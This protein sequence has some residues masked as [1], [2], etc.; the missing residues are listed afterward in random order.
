MG[1]TDEIDP[2]EVN[3]TIGCDAVRPGDLIVAD[4]TVL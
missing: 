3:V 1:D 4:T 2:F